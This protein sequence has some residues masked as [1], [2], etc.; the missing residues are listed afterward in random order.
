MDVRSTQ[1]SVAD[2]KARFSE[3]LARAEAGEEISIRR[4]GRPVARLIPPAAPE[5]SREERL[6]ARRRG[7][8][9]ALGDRRT[10]LRSAPA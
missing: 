3:L 1:F 6:A 5:L 10:G 8:R 9:G 2:A 7:E 4:H